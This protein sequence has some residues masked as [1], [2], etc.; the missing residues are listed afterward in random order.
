M[1]LH[2]II[3]AILWIAYCVLHS[4]L[5]SVGAKRR[6]QNA[7]GKAYKHYRLGYTIFAFVTLAGIL[8]YQLSIPTIHFYK[9]SFLVVILGYLV[10]VTGF[11]IML[12]CI[13][14]YFM[15]LSGLRSLLKETVDSELII[16]G[17]HRHV[18][19]PLYLGTFLFIWGLAVLAPYLS[20]IIANT[21]ITIYTVIAIRFEEEK[22]VAEFGDAYRDYQKTVPKLIPKW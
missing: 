9:P 4:V 6:I 2:H 17:I 16:S 15:S 19:H 11:G 12:T 18:R 5:A 8:W 3:L 20:L 21:I 13:K 10:T 22:L 1:V 14:K 7:L